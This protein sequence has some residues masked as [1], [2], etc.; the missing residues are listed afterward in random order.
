MPR[1]RL[2]QLG[3][4]CA[5]SQVGDLGGG[6]KGGWHEDSD[7]FRPGHTEFEMSVGDVQ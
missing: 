7:K 6:S 2:G 4:L 3:E 1:F 5:I